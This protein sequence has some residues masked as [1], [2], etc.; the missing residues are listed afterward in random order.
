MELFDCGLLSDRDVYV[1]LF[2][3]LSLSAGPVELA[4]EVLAMAAT[5]TAV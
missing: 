2:E 3:Q 4:E 5:Q 1:P